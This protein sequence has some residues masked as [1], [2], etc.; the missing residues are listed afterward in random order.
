PR[1]RPRGLATRSAE[2]PGLE[3]VNGGH[4]ALTGGSDDHGALDIATTWTEAAA[5]TPQ[6]FLWE[7]A[8]GY[9]GPSGAHGSTTKLAH[10]LTALLVN[11]YRAGGIELPELLA[12]RAEQLFDTDATDADERHAGVWD[13]M[14]SL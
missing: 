1:S 4:I 6:E 3:P 10:A 5:G 11:A 8:S 9:A 14:N 7:I 13:A 12:A 2:R